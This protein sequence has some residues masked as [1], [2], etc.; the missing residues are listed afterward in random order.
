[1]LGCKG[2]SLYERKENEFSFVIL[3][4]VKS[5]R[6]DEHSKGRQGSRLIELHYIHE[7]CRKAVDKVNIIKYS[8]FFALFLGAFA[9]L[10]KATISF[11]MSVRPSVC[12][13][14]WNN[15]APTGRILMKF[16]I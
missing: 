14:A 6:R 16:D 4:T 13:Y 5:Y 12:L 9:K 3:A 8:L 2:V 1:M 7:N 15:R 11:V 10:R